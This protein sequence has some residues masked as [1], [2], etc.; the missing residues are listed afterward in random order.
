MWLTIAAALAAETAQP[1]L[2]TWMAGCWEQKTDDRW[3]EE[4]WTG[5]RAGQ[6]MGSSRTGKGDTLQFFEHIRMTTEGG[7]VNYCALPKGQAGGCFKA[8]KVTDSEVVFEN[9][10][11]DYPQRIRYWRDGKTLAAEISLKDGTK[12]SGW[13]Y[14]PMGN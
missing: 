13:R 10:A 9:E 3:V 12:S 6:M 2:P 8:T 11:H 7:E 1:V 4:C 5:A 14:S